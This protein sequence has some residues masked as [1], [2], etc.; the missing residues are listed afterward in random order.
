MWSLVVAS[1]AF[2][3]MNIMS[4][5]ADVECFRILCRMHARFT[6]GSDD[7]DTVAITALSEYSTR[8]GFLMKAVGQAPKR[9][10]ADAWIAGMNMGC[11]GLYFLRPRPYQMLNGDPVLAVEV[12]PSRNKNFKKNVLTKESPTIRLTMTATV[13]RTNLCLTWRHIW[14]NVRKCV[15][16]WTIVFGPVFFPFNR[17]DCHSKMKIPI[18]LEVMIKEFLWNIRLSL[19]LPTQANVCTAYLWSTGIMICLVAIH[20]AV[21]T[22]ITILLAAIFVLVW[23]GLAVAVLCIPLWN[24]IQKRRA[25]YAALCRIG[26][27]TSR[28]LV[29]PGPEARIHCRSL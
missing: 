2:A 20:L 3:W 29:G 19:I 4:S 16:L 11:M 25:I 26:P 22:D 28:F 18:V 15:P 24:I 17:P 21:Y 8:P 5:M 7:G 1:F 13:L 23:F 12:L 6:A 9:Q 14:T 10:L 27:R